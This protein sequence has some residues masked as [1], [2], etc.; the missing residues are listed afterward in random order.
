MP[1]KPARTIKKTFGLFKGK[2]AVFFF[3]FFK[4]KLLKQW[5]FQ[6]STCKFSFNNSVWTFYDCC[7]CT[8]CCGVKMK[9][10]KI[11]RL[12]YVLHWED[13]NVP[14]CTMDPQAGANIFFCRHEYGALWVGTCIWFSFF[15]SRCRLDFRCS[16]SSGILPEKKVGESLI[17][18]DQQWLTSRVQP[19]VRLAVVSGVSSGSFPEPPVFSML[20]KLCWSLLYPLILFVADKSLTRLSG[21]RSKARKSGHLHES[22]ICWA[23]SA[24][25]WRLFSKLPCRDSRSI[26]LNFLLE[27]KICSWGSNLLMSCL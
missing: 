17:G 27:R 8:W 3:F 19:T 25:S 18:G 24:C 16:L 4:L 26:F 14:H 20:L 5:L 15:R 11:N 13:G 6:D 9:T 12:V 1:S 2:L 22:R 23:T 10:A 21:R 7:T